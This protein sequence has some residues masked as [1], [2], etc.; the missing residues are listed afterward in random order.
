[1][2]KFYIFISILVLATVG[3]SVLISLNR[4]LTDNILNII[5]VLSAAQSVISCYIVYLLYDRFGTSKKILDKQNDLIIEFIDEIKKIRFYVT[6]FYP[7][8]IMSVTNLSIKKDLSFAKSDP[9]LNKRL[10][11]RS[12]DF[13]SILAKV[14]EIL[15]HPLFPR[16]LNK[17]LQ[18]FSQSVLMSNPTFKKED[19][20]YISFQ[21]E[22]DFS[23]EG[24]MTPAHD[25]VTL[26]EY[27]FRIERMV[28]ELEKWINR[29]SSIKI[30]L[31]YN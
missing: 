20:A 21:Y 17:D 1:M 13:Y 25:K 4:H 11:F 23:E 26:N 14:N 3:I 9:G 8:G 7:D 18:I 15:N 24:W 16:E 6:Q 27:I 30:R 19:F 28:I 5:S 31:N 10:M 22:K 2:K 12:K 29:E